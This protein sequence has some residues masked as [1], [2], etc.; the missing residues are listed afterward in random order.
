MPRLRSES[1][2]ESLEAQKEALERRIKL[3]TAR[4]RARQAAED[5]RRWRLAGEV[6]VQLMQAAPE[7]EFFKTMMGLLDQH[8]RSAADRALF[9]LPAPKSSNGESSTDS[10]PGLLP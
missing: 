5:S 3:V 10:G 6:A 4:E 8:A 1:E 9:G 2:L 7:G